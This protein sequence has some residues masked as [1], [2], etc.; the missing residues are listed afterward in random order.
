MLIIK[1]LSCLLVT[2]S[3]IVCARRGFGVGVLLTYSSTQSLGSV[4]RNAFTADPLFVFPE[5]IMLSSV[6]TL[7]SIHWDRDEN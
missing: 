5:F 7:F 4:Q 3:A 1:H 2:V 6:I